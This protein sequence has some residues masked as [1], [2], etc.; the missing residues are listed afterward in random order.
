MISVRKKSALC[1]AVFVSLPAVTILVFSV[2]LTV[3]QLIVWI[4]DD[5][6]FVRFLTNE[7]AEKQ[8]VVPETPG[9]NE[10]KKPGPDGKTRIAG[11]VP[12]RHMDARLPDSFFSF[13]KKAGGRFFLG[14]SPGGF[15]SLGLYAAFGVYVF[16][17]PRRRV[18]A[19]CRRVRPCFLPRKNRFPEGVSAMD[20]GEDV[21]L[22]EDRTM[23]SANGEGSTFAVFWRRCRDSRPPG[24]RLSGKARTTEYV[25][26]L[27]LFFKTNSKAGMDM[28][29][30][31]GRLERENE[32]LDALKTY[33]FRIALL[34]RDLGFQLPA[35][36]DTN[37]DPLADTMLDYYA[38][39]V[40]GIKEG[41]R[42]IDAVETAKRAEEM[43]SAARRGD[44]AFL[45]ENTADFLEYMEYFITGIV[46]LTEEK[47]VFS[48]RRL[49]SRRGLSR[50]PRGFGSR[51]GKKTD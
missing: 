19:G 8:P 30:I 4:E 26:P 23:A 48:D 15:L 37:P 44:L 34:L 13:G 35:E 51:H 28:V 7:F 38:I 2:L 27:V 11:F 18:P 17:F 6:N 3:N 43:E 41:S 49:R 50:A 5:V 29:R 40:H 39:T 36:K 32:F 1:K 22:D 42:G 24:S 9:I 47:S 31:I 45:T 21:I 25:D 12:A 10:K 16:L 33:T 20:A 46:K 14:F